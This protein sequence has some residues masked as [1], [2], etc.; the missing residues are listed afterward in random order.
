[1]TKR[2]WGLFSQ[3]GKRAVSCPWQRRKADLFWEAQEL[4]GLGGK[5][6][7]G[8]SEERNLYQVEMPKGGPG[9]PHQGHPYLVYMATGRDARQW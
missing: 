1:M 8:W 4:E 9:C 6:W 5:Y 7:E 2:G 3:S